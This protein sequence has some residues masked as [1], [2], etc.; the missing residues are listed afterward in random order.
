MHFKLSIFNKMLIAPLL[1]VILFTLYII[2]INNHLIES[3]KYMNSIYQEY[4]PILNIANEN[5][6]LFEN[7]I[8]SFEDAVVAGEE[9]WLENSTNNKNNINNNF[10]KLK[11]LGIEEHTIVDMKNI[12]IQYYNITKELSILMLQQSNN[13]NK[14]YRLTKAM[15][16]Y[17]DETKVVFEKFKN[18]QNMKLQNT[19][20]I[21]NE[22]GDNILHLGVIIGFFSL[23]LIIV[24]TISLS[25]STKKSLKELLD[26]LKKIANGNPDFS[27][28]LQKSSDDELG[29]VVEEFN[30]FTKKLQKDYEELAIAKVDAEAANKIK[31][32]FV[33]NM[34]H[35]IRTP[36]NAIIGFSE[37]LNKTEASSKQKSY[38]GA[39]ATGGNTLLAII[40]DI[41][42]IS[43][44]EAGK[45]QIQNEEVAI[46]PVVHDICA[47]F[48]Q[49]IKNKS[50]EFHLVI[51]KNLPELVVID[52]IR[53]RQIL[54]NLVG[55]AIKFTHE[56]YI[57]IGIYTSNFHNDKFDLQIDIKDTGIG[58]APNQQKKIFESFVQQDGQK[59]RQ[60]GGTGLGLAICLKLIKMMNGDIQLQ[61]KEK[62]GSTFSIIFNN[63]TIVNSK[64]KIVKKQDQEVVFEN[65]TI[66]VVDDEVLNRLYI[67]ESLK[68][69]NFTI[70]EASNGEEAI[71]KVAKYKP[72]LI[73]MDIKMPIMDGLEATKIL[74]RDPRFKSIPIVALTA[75]VK[76]KSVENIAVLFSGYITKP[77]HF[78]I[79]LNELKKFIKFNVVENSNNVEDVVYQLQIDEKIK[80]IFLEEFHT[81]INQYWEKAA[82]GCSFEDILLFANVLNKFA[83]KFMQQSL[84]AFTKELNLSIESFDVIKIEDLINQFTLFIKNLENSK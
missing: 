41:L 35:E 82:E 18:E 68:D 26:S 84:I 8:R 62:E 57:E 1:A 74:K 36:L 4:F 44:I 42:D 32:E 64:R 51:P 22:Y 71:D 21:T 34:S 72:D 33:A 40:N 20:N 2:N 46:V 49:K 31:S 80:N 66:L 19:I 56:G 27:K 13:D 43:K 47:I 28:R 76:E 78:D 38:L 24:L 50:L 65:S 59:N 5:I 10:E 45:M 83:V 48:E 73:L 58:I 54:L 11:K 6:I 14:I 9:S 15:I 77:L 7:T 12:F 75:S 63:L 23:A 81:N 52:A 70:I 17:L 30:K 3:K 67:A 25:F 79:L 39:I 60:Y 16:V 69:K 29:E 55:N 37:L 61:S 53:L